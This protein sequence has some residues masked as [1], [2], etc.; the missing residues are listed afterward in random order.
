MS[1]AAKSL[2]PAAAAGQNMPFEEALA[3]LEAI[4]AAMESGDLPLESLLVKFEEGARLDMIC[5]AKLAEAEL[6][7]KQ[8]EKNAAGELVLKP[9]SIADDE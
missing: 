5:R 3:R 6:K 9:L 8:L 1:K 7:I 2:T 4:V